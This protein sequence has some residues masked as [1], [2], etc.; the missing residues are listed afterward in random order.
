MPT[1]SKVRLER[2]PS[3]VLKD[4]DKAAEIAL[5][6]GFR[7]VKTPRIEKMDI[8][9]ANSLVSN[10]SGTDESQKNIFPR[11][12]EKISLLRTFLSWNINPEQLPIMLHYKRPVS[13]LGVRH[14]AD[15]RHYSLDIIGSFDSVSEAIAIRTAIAILADHGHDKLTVDINSLGDKYSIGQFERELINFCR[16]HGSDMPPEVR[17]QL[18]RD[19]FDVWRCQ[20]EKW[21]EVKKRAPQSLSFLSENSV[22]NF[23][24][25]LEYLE[26]LEIPY[27]INHNLIG[28]RHYCS[29][30]VFEIKNAGSEKPSSDNNLDNNNEEVFAVGTRHNYLARR[31][32]F[33][34]DLPMVS[35][36]IRFKKPAA[37]PKLFFKIKPNPKFFFIQFGS[38]AK[39]KSLPV[40]EALRQARIPVHHMLTSD[41]FIG[42]LSTAESLKTP[43][44]IIMGQK[45]AL[46]NTVVV[47]H[48][49]SRS[50]E[51][52]PIP[53]LP[54]Y[55]SKMGP[56]ALA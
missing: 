39:L 20:H 53:N 28:H 5:F 47:R 54:I 18:R 36:N 44:I 42:Q 11:A 23:R 25:V 8:E 40:I 13:Q 29:H 19:P 38:I 32:G 56:G 3:Y 17:Q 37:S 41:K 22:D 7:P 27:R 21:L 30:T 55:L 46:E 31:V 52:V 4:L 16:K 6:Y 35:V 10:T 48:M 12:E 50:Q 2:E 43:Y 51:I 49:G 15:E 26:N 24:Q 14:P 34:R 45:E 9:L 33:K 1:N